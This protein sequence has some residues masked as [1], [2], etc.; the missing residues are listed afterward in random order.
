MPRPPRDTGGGERSLLPL[1]FLPALTALAVTPASNT[2]GTSSRTYLA[3]SAWNFIPIDSNVKYAYSSNP[4]G[5][6][7]TNAT[8]YSWF[9]AGFQLPAG[10]IVDYLELNVCDSTPTGNISAYVHSVNSAGIFAVLGSF[11]NATGIAE[12]PGCVVRTLT[13]TP[14]TVDN[15][16]YAYNIE[17]SLTESGTGLMIIGARIG[18]KLQVSPPPGTPTFGDVPTTH[19]FYQ[20]IEALAASGVTAGCG[21]GNYCPDAALTRGQMAVFLA[22]ALGLHWAP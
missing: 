12:T 3:L 7:R 14:F 11:S 19:A 4:S 9:H 18:Y 17:I 6:Y 10:A 22:K 20:Y 16:A 2:Y 15:N 21:S 1:L 13:L 8:V 5:I